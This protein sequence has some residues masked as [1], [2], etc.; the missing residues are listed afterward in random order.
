MFFIFPWKTDAPIYYLPIVTVAMIVINTIVFIYIVA[1]PHVVRDLALIH[2]NGLHPLQWLTSNFIHG[3][4]FHLLGNMVFLWVFGL[5]VEGK[6]GWMRFLTVFLGIGILQNALVQI[7]M[8]GA[9]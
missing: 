9:P 2:G 4:I 6:L 1:I 7:V 8:L 3:R 5:V